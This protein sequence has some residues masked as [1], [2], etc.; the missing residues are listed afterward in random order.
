M[1]PFHPTLPP[2]GRLVRLSVVLDY[3]DPP[4][5][6]LQLAR[7]CDRAGIGAVWIEAADPLEA[8][9]VLEA[10]A[11]ATERIRL[12]L[13]AALPSGSEG[14][15]GS[16][17]ALTAL[18]TS[19]VA[20]CGDRAELSLRSRPA[21]SPRSASQT[22]L[23]L[24]VEAEPADPTAFAP[25][26]ALADDLLLLAGT[27]EQVAADAAAL[28]RACTAVGREPATLGIAARLPVSIGRTIAE[29]WA[30]WEAEPAFTPLGDPAETAIFGTLEQCHDRVLVL[31]HAGVTDL[32]CKLPNTADVHDVIAQITA[33]TIGTTDKLTPGAPRSPAP[34]PP[35]GWGGRSRFP[36]GSPAEPQR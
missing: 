8:G 2:P 17:E 34:P 14:S 32:R 36:G 7:M 25:W 5:R 30:R 29:A 16:G 24:S 3:R 19:L 20:A 35:S 26:L 23:T 33:M 10:L 15:E 9:G 22:N 1:L 28:R 11:A 21:P 12:G 13:R 6:L 4:E 31:A 18:A 27:V